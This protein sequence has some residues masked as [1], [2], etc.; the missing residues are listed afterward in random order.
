[1]ARQ[2]ELAELAR[3]ERRPDHALVQDKLVDTQ[4]GNG[5]FAWRIEGQVRIVA[6]TAPRRIV[7]VICVHYDFR[8]VAIL[9]EVLHRL[10]LFLRGDL[11]CET[12]HV[13]ESLLDDA[14]VL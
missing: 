13:D 5:A 6:G 7:N 8:Q 9:A 2:E 11:W 12:N 14:Q 1:M 10:Q 4:N 3:A